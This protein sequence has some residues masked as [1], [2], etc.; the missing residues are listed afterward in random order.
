[1]AITWIHHE[2]YAVGEL[3]KGL[4]YKTPIINDRAQ[5]L[6]YGSQSMLRDFSMYN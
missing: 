6:E 2:I 1:M 5:S 3:K 4:R